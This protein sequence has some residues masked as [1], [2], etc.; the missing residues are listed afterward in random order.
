MTFF[1]FQRSLVLWLRRYEI[2]LQNDVA[3]TNS[4]IDRRC[5]FL[6]MAHY[7]AQDSVSR[8]WRYTVILLTRNIDKDVFFNLMG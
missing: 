8:K 7:A 4:I 6:N 5:R 2:L 3:R 1:C